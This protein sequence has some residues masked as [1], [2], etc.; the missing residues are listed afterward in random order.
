MRPP[1]TRRLTALALAVLV[2]AVGATPAFAA[3][4]ITIEYWHINS[5]TFGG[6][7]VKEL[8]QTFEAKHPGIKIVE[9]FQPGV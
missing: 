1:M 8:V 5:P 7:A 6:P 9:K 2:A 4:P 3:E